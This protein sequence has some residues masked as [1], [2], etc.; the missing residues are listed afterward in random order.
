MPIRRIK[1]HQAIEEGNKVKIITES[2]RLSCVIVCVIMALFISLKLGESLTSEFNLFAV[3]AAIALGALVGS[4][5][6][7][8]EV[9]L[10]DLVEIKRYDWPKRVTVILDD[11]RSRMGRPNPSPKPTA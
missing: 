10:A 1:A 4:S 7:E 9:P 8:R 5:E 2:D 11:E 3:L 6:I